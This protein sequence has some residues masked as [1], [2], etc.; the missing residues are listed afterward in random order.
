[1]STVDLLRQ[2]LEL[3]KQRR[4]ERPNPPLP[5]P[6]PVQGFDIVRHEHEWAL[7]QQA[8]RAARAG[9]WSPFGRCWRIA[10]E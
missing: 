10:D 6:M 1:M 4:M 5:E 7:V 9:P 8:R 2:R 3:H